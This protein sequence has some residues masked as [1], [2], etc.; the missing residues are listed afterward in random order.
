MKK[1]LLILTTLLCV[2]FL[3]AQNPIQEVDTPLPNEDFFTKSELV[4]EGISLK[5]VANYDTKGNRNKDEIFRIHA[6]SVLKVFKGD[7]SLVGD[8]VYITENGGV[9]GAEN[10]NDEKYDIEY[11]TPYIFQK[12]EVSCTVTRFEPQ[13]FFLVTSDI[14][15]IKDSKYSPFKKYKHFTKYTN[16]FYG[17]IFTNKM[18]VCGNFIGGLND[19]LFLSREEFYNYIKKFEGFTV[20]EPVSINEKQP[21]KK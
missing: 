1:T 15:D 2:S 3:Y 10:W 14:T 8:I 5:W 20:P 17:Y 16:D 6:V 19:L 11:Y 9:L 12:N 13:I 21:E 7:Q 4:I 18:Y